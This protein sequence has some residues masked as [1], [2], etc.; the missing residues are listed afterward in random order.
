MPDLIRPN[1]KAKNDAN[2]RMT[3]NDYGSFVHPGN[4]T[5]VTS[6]NSNVFIPQNALMLPPPPPQM[7]HHVPQEGLGRPEEEVLEPGRRRRRAT[8][9]D[10]HSRAPLGKKPK[11]IS[12]S[13]VGDNDCYD[14]N[15]LYGA[16]KSGRVAPQA[17]VDDWIEQ[18]K[19]NRD[20]AMLELM[21]FFISCSGCRGKI[22]PE[23]YSRMSHADIIRRMTEEFDEDSGEY[24][25][26]QTGPVWR[27]FR[28]YFVDFIAIL[29]RH[30]QYSIIYD[31]YM[32][33]QIIALL[34]G[35]TDSQVRAFRHTSTL[36]SMKMMTALVDVA[37]TVSINLDN[38]QRQ[39]EAERSKSKSGRAATDRLDV[40]MRK[41]KE[42]EENMNEVKNMMTYLFKGVF[43]H[44]YR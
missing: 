41:R 3:L 21:Q 24:P 31:Q 42:L 26:I 23:M 43:V 44:R 38:T 30:C 14:E 12:G 22:T 5:G 9:E 18:Y 4:V 36:A 37:L 7:P 35:L 13:K 40:L 19:S 11:R 2:T 20:A 29:I 8:D 6:P 16:I 1:R 10:E 17:L 32:M 27:R 34:T 39:Y 28:S 15:S 33:E 25:L